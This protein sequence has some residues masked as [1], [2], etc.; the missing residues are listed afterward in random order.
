MDGVGLLVPSFAT[1][2][3]RPVNSAE[4]I[5]VLNQAAVAAMGAVDEPVGPGQYRYI[6]THA[7]W[8]TFSGYQVFQDEN[9]IRIWVPADPPQDWM[10]DR[11]PTGNRIWITGDEQQARVDGTFMDALASGVTLRAAA[12]CGNFYA[13]GPCPRGGSWQDPTPAFLADLPR[14]PALL[15][16]RLQADAPVNDRGSADCSSTPPT[17]CGPGWS[18]PTCGQRSTKR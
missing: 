6:E 13:P 14:D 12:P 7:W 15:Y 1:S 16:A 10:L 4:A 8:T 11:R 5:G 2:R 9:L 18:R 3:N 17:P